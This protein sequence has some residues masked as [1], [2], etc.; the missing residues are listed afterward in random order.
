MKNELIIKKCNSCGA[1]VKVIEDCK[2]GDCGIKCCGEEMRTFA[3]N[4]EDA[5]FEKHLPIV[6]V[7]GADM[8][9]YVLPFGIIEG[10]AVETPEGLAQHTPI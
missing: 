6:E 9:T 7:V 10:I 5:S 2:C 4:S 3:P 1:M 8:L